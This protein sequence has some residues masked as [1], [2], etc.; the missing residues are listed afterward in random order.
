MCVM[1]RVCVFKQ[2]I[3]CETGHSIEG[4]NITRWYCVRDSIILGYRAIVFISESIGQSV[5]QVS[6][7]GGGTDK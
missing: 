5:S 3:F 4:M 1:C 2:E 6:G 7:T